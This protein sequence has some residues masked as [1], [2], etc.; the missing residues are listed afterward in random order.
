MVHVEWITS[1]LLLSCDCECRSNRTSGI[2]C[3]RLDIHSAVRCS[4]I[5]LPI[6]DG[7]HRT[8]TSQSHSVNVMPLMQALQQMKERFFVH[9][10]ER[11][12]DVPMLLCDLFMSLSW[13]AEQID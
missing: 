10:L 7:V 13:R 4:P 12:G 9:A 6:R 3:G 2:S 5:D 1:D 11:V 8:T